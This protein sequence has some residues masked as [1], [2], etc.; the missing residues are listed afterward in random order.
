MAQVFRSN[1]VYKHLAHKLNNKNEMVAVRGVYVSGEYRP[2]YYNNPGIR[3]YELTSSP[4]T[5]VDFEDKSTTNGE[6][7]FVKI[8]EFSMTR[9][10][11]TLISYTTASQ[12]AGEGSMVKIVDLMATFTPPSFQFY[13]SG[14]QNAGEGAFVK[15]ID[16]KT[17]FASNYNCTTYL[18]DKNQSTPE[19][20]LRLSSISSEKATIENYTS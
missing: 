8:V 18:R 20:I 11:P 19:P 5:V 10:Q 2:P 7:P 3:I 17:E 9:L 1:E 6:D 12:D 16:F 15:I 14:S 13:E 4:A